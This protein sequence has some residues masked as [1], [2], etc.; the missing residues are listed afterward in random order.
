MHLCIL[1]VCLLLYDSFETSSTQ[2]ILERVEEA[3]FVFSVENL[4]HMCRKRNFSQKEVARRNRL[5]T[6]TTSKLEEGKSSDPRRKLAKALDCPI[7]VFF[8]EES[9]HTQNE[10]RV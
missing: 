9:V 5:A 10:D 3:T 7:E 8:S 1:R 4:V 2:H 6:V